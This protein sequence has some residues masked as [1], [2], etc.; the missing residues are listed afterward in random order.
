MATP[1]S[2]NALL[3]LDTGTRDVNAKL[4]VRVFLKR[5]V[6]VMRTDSEQS[7]VQARGG[8]A[9]VRVVD[10]RLDEKDNGSRRMLPK[11]TST[12]AGVDCGQ[13]ESSRNTDVVSSLIPKGTNENKKKKTN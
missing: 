1:S 3:A 2:G 11:R 13:F 6:T 4:A 5:S 12:S 8:M 10:C 7:S 9:T